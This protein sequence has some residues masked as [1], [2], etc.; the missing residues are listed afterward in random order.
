MSVQSSPYLFGDNVRVVNSLIKDSNAIHA[1]K[2]S[3]ITVVFISSKDTNGALSFKSPYHETVFKLMRKTQCICVK[4]FS[5]LNSLK[6]GIEE[7]EDLY[8]RKLSNVFIFTH[9]NQKALGLVRNF[10]TETLSSLASNVRIYVIGCAAG[11]KGGILED[12]VMAVPQG[13][14]VFG[15]TKILRAPLIENCGDRFLLHSFPPENPDQD[16]LRIKSATV[17][18]QRTKMRFKKTLLSSSSQYL[19]AYFSEAK[20][21]DPTFQACLGLIYYY[22]YGVGRSYPTACY[23][24]KEAAR[25]GHETGNYMLSRLSEQDYKIGNTPSKFSHANALYYLSKA[26][27]SNGFFSSLQNRSQEKLSDLKIEKLCT[28]LLNE[29]KKNKNNKDMPV[30]QEVMT[31]LQVG[32][33]Q[34]NEIA[35][36]YFVEASTLLISANNMPDL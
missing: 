12:L 9:A 13:V 24:F 5:D 17:V 29:I 21:G 26:K 18:Y 8:K 4:Y 34:G 15:S 1:A 31:I 20:K 19:S 35:R 36:R 22:G 28:I 11:E 27:T 14:R 7:V 10:N 32:A 23:W 2:N 6:I 16:G 3:P 30:L 25:N 33:I